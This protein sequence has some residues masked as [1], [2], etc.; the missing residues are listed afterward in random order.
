[1]NFCKIAKNPQKYSNSKKRITKECTYEQMDPET[2]EILKEE[3]YK[4]IYVDKEP[5]Y[6]KLYLGS[7]DLLDTDISSLAKYIAGLCE[8]AT[9]SNDTNDLLQ[10]TVRTT[11]FEKKAIANKGNI[12]ISR[13]E[14]AITALIKA[15][16]LIPVH[17][18]NT[19]EE[20]QKGVYHL[21]PWILARGEWKDIKKL[22][23]SCEFERDAKAKT[24]I[25]AK[26]IRHTILSISDNL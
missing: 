2:G 19:G 20:Q 14:Q 10:S 4:D 24:Y 15:E 26:G 23:D 1:M 11:S 17:A 5:P 12:K 16:L 6:I 7:L 8:F 3:N 18:G 21:N 13:V 22:R 25:D 9:Y